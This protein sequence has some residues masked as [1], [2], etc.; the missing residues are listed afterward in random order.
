MNPHRCIRA[1]KRQ[2]VLRFESSSFLFILRFYTLLAFSRNECYI[3]SDKRFLNPRTVNSSSHINTVVVIIIFLWRL[4]I[5][6]IVDL[7]I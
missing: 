5:F 1:Q 2:G 3:Q 7:Y 4:S 6:D